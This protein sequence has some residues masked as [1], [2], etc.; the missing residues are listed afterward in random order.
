MRHTMGRLGCA[1]TA[2]VGTQST[3][4]ARTSATAT[5]ARPRTLRSAQRK[6]RQAAPQCSPCHGPAHRRMRAVACT[7]KEL[8]TYFG[9]RGRMLCISALFVALLGLRRPMQ[10]EQ[11]QWPV[12]LHLCGG[13][14]I[15]APDGG[16]YDAHAASR[17]K[18]QAQRHHC[19]NVL[20]PRPAEPCGFAT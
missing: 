7:G 8:K 12:R 2:W 13:G 17:A 5:P 20:P 16:G 15:K 3:G 9:K 10:R 19:L 14:A 18:E 6:R 4:Q 11:L 1:R